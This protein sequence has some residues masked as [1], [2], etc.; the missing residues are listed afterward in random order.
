[1]NENRPIFAL[2]YD[3]DKTLSPKDMQE[4]GFI[5]GIKMEAEELEKMGKGLINKFG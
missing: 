4:Y 3:F 2:M 5:P 1:M